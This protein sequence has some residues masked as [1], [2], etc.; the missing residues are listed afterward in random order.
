MQL[1]Q[2]LYN[3]VWLVF[4]TCVLIPRWMGAVVG[5]PVHAFLGLALLVVS[6]SNL[7]RLEALPVPPRLK[8]IGKAVAGYAIFQLLCGLALG[9]VVHLAPNLTILSY[10]LRGAHLVGACAILAKSASLATGHDMWEEKEFG[11]APSD[12]KAG[13]R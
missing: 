5:M 8:R 2:K 10:I 4:F 9:A 12:L 11:D 13:D 6:W 1:W 3:A 7:R